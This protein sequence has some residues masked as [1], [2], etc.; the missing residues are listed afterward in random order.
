[1]RL[2]SSDRPPNAP[3]GHNSA[4]EYLQARREALWRGVT[5]LCVLLMTSMGFIALT[6]AAGVHHGWVLAL[7]GG[8]LSIVGSAAAHHARI[9]RS[10]G[11]VVT[12]NQG[13]QK[14]VWDITD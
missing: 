4:L 1:M 8:T 11:R 10:Y 2:T 13:R 6:A 14:V 12:D 5:S 3:G 9:V 7:W